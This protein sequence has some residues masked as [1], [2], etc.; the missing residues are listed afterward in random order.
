MIEV[1]SHIEFTEQLTNLT[2]VLDFYADWCGP[3][4]AITPILQEIHESGTNVYK[5]NVDEQQILASQYDVR[6]IPAVFFLRD[7]KV[8]DFISGAVA[9]SKFI[10]AASKIGNLK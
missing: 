8:V 4:K 10:E 9:K 6:S 5:I 1:D 7:G 3:C 2:G